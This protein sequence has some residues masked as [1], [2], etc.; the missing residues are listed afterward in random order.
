[1]SPPPCIAYSDTD[2]FRIYSNSTGHIQVQDFPL[3]DTAGS[4]NTTS[5]DGFTLGPACAFNY[6]T[7]YMLGTNDQ[8]TSNINDT[9]LSS[10]T[11]RSQ[12]DLLYDNGMYAP[13]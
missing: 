2:L 10:H 5:F 6:P 13:D 8:S 12:M 7:L 4:Y 9:G 11:T 3:S 1:M